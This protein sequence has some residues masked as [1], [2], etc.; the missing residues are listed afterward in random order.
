MQTWRAVGCL[1]ACVVV[2][3]PAAANGG[4]DRVKS[5]LSAPFTPRVNS[6]GV[7]RANAA[8]SSDRR[9][10]VRE[11]VLKLMLSVD[12]GPFELYDKDTTGLGERNTPSA[13]YRFYAFAQLQGPRD[14]VEGERITLF[15]KARSKQ[16]GGLICSG[17]RT[18]RKTYRVDEL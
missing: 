16:R 1:A 11:R 3:A 2:L 4:G 5:R 7:L 8:V 17:D 18:N 12:G 9:D 15:W 6:D 13:R 14:T 10:C